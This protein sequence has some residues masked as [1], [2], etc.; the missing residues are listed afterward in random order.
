MNDSSAHYDRVTEAWRQ[1]VMGEALHFGLFTNRDQPLREATDNLTQ[2]LIDAANI[3]EPHRV[4][5]VGCGIGTP[6]RAIARRCGCHVVGITTSQVG[7]TLAQEATTEPELQARTQFVL[8]DSGVAVMASER[9]L[10]SRLPEGVDD[11]VW[12][13]EP[14]PTNARIHSLPEPGPTHSAY[15]IYTSGSTGRP[16]GAQLSHAGACNL[17]AAQRSA[18]G[19][20]HRDIVV[21]LSSPGFDASVFELLLALGS[22]AT[23]VMGG[24]DSLTAGHDLASFIRNNDVSVMVATPSTL[25]VTPD[26]DL[27]CLRVL[28]TAGEACSPALVERWS[29]PTRSFFNAYGPTEATVW[30][31]VRQ[32][33]PGLPV[34]IGGPIDNVRAHVLDDTGQPMP[35]GWPGELCV[36]GASVG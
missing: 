8:K 7:L 24:R 4:L 2:R 35:I 5:D 3:A 6:A 17:I 28:I 16:K 21:Q 26:A 30:T 22:G 20:T 10:A 1:W 18:F 32:C 12:I 19:L 33:Q 14:A 23:I 31:T 15:Q 11:V 9:A 25:Q 29:Q 34:D 36:G 13:E 27:P